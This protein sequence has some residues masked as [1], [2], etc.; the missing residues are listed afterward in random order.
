[1]T[2]KRIKDVRRIPEILEYGERWHKKSQYS[3]VKFERD[4]ARE[5]IRAA[6]IFPNQALWVSEDRDGKIQGLL[7]ASLQHY[8]FSHRCYATDM[9]FVADRQ[10]HKLFGAFRTWA[11][12]HEA[13][14]IQ[15]GI[16]SGV[17]DPERLGKYYEKCGLA[18]LGGIYSIDLRTN[19]SLARK[20]KTDVG[21]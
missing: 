16:T 8:V 20:N 21:A 13:E 4:W 2:V 5:F 3:V 14:Q 1:M 11:K 6:I 15:V 12:E 10:G 19:P 9:I 17:G 7:I 18:R